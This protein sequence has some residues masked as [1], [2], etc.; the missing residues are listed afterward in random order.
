MDMKNNGSAYKRIKGFTL[1]ELIVVIAI[2]SVLA[3]VLNMAIQNYVRNAK[4]ETLNDR[5]QMVYMA[6]QDMLIDCELKQD[7]SMFDPRVEAGDSAVDD[8]IGAVVF[9][10]ICGEDV[11]GHRNMRGSMGLGDEIH[12]MTTHRNTIHYG[13]TPNICSMSVWPEGSSDPCITTGA[14]ANGYPDHGASYWNK[15]N[16]YIAGRMD[17]TAT[18]TYVVSLDL[19]NYQ[20]ISVIC[21]SVGPDSKDPKTGLYSE[22]EVADSNKALGKY[23]NYYSD[24][25]GHSLKEKGTGIEIKP[26]QRTFILKNTDQQRAI[27]SKVGVDMG[28]YP[29]G[30][31]LY[32]NVESPIS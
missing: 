15:Y 24:E 19:E 17:E 3:G 6:F 29:Y 23:I 14:G 7:L 10:R 21:R 32:S 9:F 27:S 30:D 18:G 8:I 5:A 28:S 16:H 25:G 2:I 4:L 31:T 11:Y 12:I 1:V 13:I 20:V 26:P 22:W